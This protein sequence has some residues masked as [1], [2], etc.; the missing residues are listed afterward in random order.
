MKR[1]GRKPETFYKKYRGKI[2]ELV[3]GFMESERVEAYIGRALLAMIGLGGIL[4]IGAVTPNIFSAFGKF[5]QKHR[6]SEKQII[7][8][9]F[10]LRKRGLVKL[11]KKSEKT[12]E[13]KITKQGRTMLIE[14]A[15]ESLKLKNQEKW[16]G[17]WRVVVFD[18]PERDGDARR[19]LRRKFKEL[20][21]FQLQRSVFIYPYP[22]EEEIQFIGAFFDVE[23]YIEIL[24]VER[25]LDD[26]DLRKHFQL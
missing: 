10:Y 18:I 19:A 14:F 21:L 8:S 6:Y 5:H 7:A 4:L 1:R 12:H 20:G 2:K 25:M 15:I 3:G 22:L 16:D 13:I 24:T 11:I 23:K 17:K 9:Y 26:K